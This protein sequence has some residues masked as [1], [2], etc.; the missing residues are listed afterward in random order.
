MTQ[1]YPKFPICIILPLGIQNGNV[2]SYSNDAEEGVEASNEIT[3]DE[4]EYPVLLDN[5]EQ[6]NND[7]INHEYE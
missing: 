5:S 7:N 3:A 1:Y 4:S 6:R 2:N